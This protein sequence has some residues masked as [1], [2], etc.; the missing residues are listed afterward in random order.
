MARYYPEYIM[1]AFLEIVSIVFACM[2]WPLVMPTVTSEDNT[3]I[4]DTNIDFLFLS[5]KRHNHMIE[6]VYSGF[7]IT[8]FMLAY[9][10]SRLQ[11]RVSKLEDTVE[12]LLQATENMSASALTKVDRIDHPAYRDPVAKKDATL[13]EL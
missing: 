11:S 13:T 2:S 9:F 12:K 8:L 6:V 4:M 7:L 3:V 10:H 1:Y 5:S